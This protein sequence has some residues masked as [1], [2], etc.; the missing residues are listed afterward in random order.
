MNLWCQCAEE[1]KPDSVRK[2]WLFICR[3]G[4]TIDFIVCIEYRRRD[5]FVWRKQLVKQI[6]WTVIL[7]WDGI[8]EKGSLF[9]QN[10]YSLSIRK[11]M[12]FRMKQIVRNCFGWYK[13][14]IGNYSNLVLLL[15]RIC[16]HHSPVS[17]DFY[18]P[19]N[20]IQCEIDWSSPHQYSCRFER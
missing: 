2:N 20:K 12:A 18:F 7:F 14:S 15:H 6:I 17:I 3:N 19:F 9:V 1:K 16:W 13:A 8:K 4:Q 10:N 5:V 11:T